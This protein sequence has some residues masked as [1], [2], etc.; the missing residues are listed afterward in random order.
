MIFALIVALASVLAGSVASVVG[1]GIGSLLT[2]LLAV[3]VGTQLAVAAISIPHVFATALRF[4]RLRAH[5]DRRVLVSFGIA[6]AAGGL[7]GALLHSYASNRALAI[8]FGVILSFVGVSELSG[9]AGRMRFGGSVAWIAG[10]L[11]GLFGGLV[12]NQGGIRSAALLGFD[13]DKQAFVATATAIGLVVDGARMPVYFWTQA[14]AIA[15]IW[16]LVLIA[17]L[18]T[19]AGTLVGV[20]GLRRIPEHAFRRIVAVILLVLGTYMTLRG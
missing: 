17:T 3:R 2:P 19:L 11:S 15:R 16:P 1:F 13:V 12:G 5:V 4:W 9:L 6:S 10:A 18:G 7:V 14:A 20:R 8:V